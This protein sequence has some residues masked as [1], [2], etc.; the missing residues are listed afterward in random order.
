MPAIPVLYQFAVWG[1]CWHTTL[2]T[3]YRGLLLPSA[4]P[5]LLHCTLPATTLL[6]RFDRF[7]AV[8]KDN[9]GQACMC[10]ARTPLMPCHVWEMRD[11]VQRQQKAA[12]GGDSILN[13][14]RATSPPRLRFRAQN[15]TAQNTHCLSLLKHSLPP[16][17]HACLASLS[18]A[19]ILPLSCAVVHL[20][21]FA[22]PRTCGTTVERAS[23]HC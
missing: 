5:M 9:H 6:D 11:N 18:S 2:Q 23:P 20:S 17:S 14:G 12:H 4:H 16:A 8:Y 21:T 22:P 10:M 1:L 19:R 13:S 15:T 7:S 3:M